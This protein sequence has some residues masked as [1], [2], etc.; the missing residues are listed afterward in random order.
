SR[1]IATECTAAEIERWS[2]TSDTPAGRLHHLAPVVR[3]SET[4]PR[5]ARPSVPLGYHAPAWP[6]RRAS[7]CTVLGVRDAASGRRRPPRDRGDDRAVRAR[8]Q[9]G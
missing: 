8:R 5:W 1:Y 2:M 9:D 6:A 3:L 4:P 7:H